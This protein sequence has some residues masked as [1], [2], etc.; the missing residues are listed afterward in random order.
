[1][2]KPKFSWVTWALTGATIISIIL[3]IIGAATHNDTK[4]TW[5]ELISYY[6]PWEAQI[7]I[8]AALAGWLPFHFY[9]NRKT[10][11]TEQQQEEQV[12]KEAARYTEY[13]KNSEKKWPE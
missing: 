2:P 6:I 8:Y 12:N 9:R 1:M 5:T 11:L 3:E 4:D 7:A 13:L 10:K